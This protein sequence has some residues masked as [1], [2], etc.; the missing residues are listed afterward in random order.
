[1]TKKSKIITK[2]KE[3]DVAETLED[4]VNLNGDMLDTYVRA[5]QK[6][7][8]NVFA[9][10]E[11]LM[12]FAG[13]RFEKDMEAFQSLTQ[14]KNSDEFVALQSDFMRTTAEDYQAEITKLVEQGTDTLKAFSVDAVHG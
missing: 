2:K 9:V 6:L 11:E 8:D 4:M 7:F 13:N 12:R 14:C 3:V 5:S 10:N 1:M